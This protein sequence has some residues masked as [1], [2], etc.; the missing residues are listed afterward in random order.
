MPGG[1]VVFDA[2][3]KGAGLGALE[4]R[5]FVLNATIRDEIGERVRY[6][7]HVAFRSRLAREKCL[8]VRDGAKHDAYD[9]SVCLPLFRAPR[10]RNSD[11]YIR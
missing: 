6:G 5:F 11:I 1:G 8:G 9:R 7:D 4:E 10:T 3:V 2:S